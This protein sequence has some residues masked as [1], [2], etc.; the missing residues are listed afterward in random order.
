MPSLRLVEA[1]DLKLAIYFF[2][3]QL[4]ELATYEYGFCEIDATAL[5][6]NSTNPHSWIQ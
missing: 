4:L 3:T 1:F 5:L 2:L 6:S